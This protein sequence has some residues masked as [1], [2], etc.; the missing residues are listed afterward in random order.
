MK[1]TAEQ[2]IS[3]VHLESARQKK[4]DRE[5]EVANL[6]GR[7]EGAQDAMA[8]I[9]G[10]IRNLIKLR[11]DGQLPEDAFQQIRFG[12]MEARKAVQTSLVEAMRARFTA[13]GYVFGYVKAEHIFQQQLDAHE[14]EVKEKAKAAQ[15]AKRKA[16]KKVSKK[17]KKPKAKETLKV[18]S[19]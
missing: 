6:I 16:S 8:R 14:Q 5:K 19:K 11:E 12:A 13:E 15:K 17:P 9:D 4:E 7:A 10:V 2:Q 3:T 18:V 1:P